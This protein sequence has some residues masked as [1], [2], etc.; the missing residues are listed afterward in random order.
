MFI[1]RAGLRAEARTKD[2]AVEVTGLLREATPAL[3]VFWHLSL[4]IGSNA[5]ATLDNVLKDLVFQVLRH[6]YT[7]V[8]QDPHLGS[9]QAFQAEHNHR[10]WTQL[11][12]RVLCKIPSCFVV[13]ET[14]DIYRRD[15][16]SSDIVQRIYDTFSHIFA[17]VVK[18]GC[19]LK[20]L[21]VTYGLRATVGTVVAQT[22][23]IVASLNAPLPAVRRRKQPMIPQLSIGKGRHQLQPRLKAR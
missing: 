11:A 2:M 16:P 9:I 4:P 19:T 1:V 6:D 7:I 10:E 17:E 15:G 18:A 13:I 21:L 8:S 5:I 22:E 14:E 12:I 20:L 3:P 23:P